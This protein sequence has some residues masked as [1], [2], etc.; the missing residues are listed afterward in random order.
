[1][2]EPKESRPAFVRLAESA[3]ACWLGFLPFSA[4]FNELLA[5]LLR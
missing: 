3:G 5:V 1:M 2:V 4:G